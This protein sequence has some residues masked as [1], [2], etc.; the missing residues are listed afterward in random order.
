MPSRKDSG[1]ARIIEHKI[2]QILCTAHRQGDRVGPPMDLES[3][4]ENF[5]VIAVEDRPMI[6]EAST[7]PTNG[8]FR[9]YLRNNF[10][11]SEGGTSRRRF[12]LAHEFC[13][14]LFYDWSTEVPKRVLGA[15]VGENV[16]AL[17]HRGAGLLLVPTSLLT[18]QVQSLGARL[19]AKNVPGLASK[20]KVS[21]EVILRR[22]QEVIEPPVDQS[23]ILVGPLGEDTDAH[24]LGSYSGPWILSHLAAPTYGLSLDD[25]LKSTSAKTAF[26]HGEFRRGVPGGTLLAR[27]P[28]SLSRG[29]ILLDVSMELAQMVAPV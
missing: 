4:C 15:P 28:V 8:G 23:I 11:E 2:D 3:L 1:W 17:C 6:P 26:L 13:H 16:E 5:R 22:L 18:S 24:I 7:E 14:T 19:T 10:L 9:V 20:F 21:I 29:R 12:T 25:W 27:E